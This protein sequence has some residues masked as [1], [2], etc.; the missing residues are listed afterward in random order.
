M[1]K[2]ILGIIILLFGAFKGGIGIAAM[3]GAFGIPGLL[4]V[5]IGAFLILWSIGD[6][7]KKISDYFGGQEITKYPNGDEYIGEYKDGVKHGQGTLNFANGDKYIGGFKNDIFHG[8]G[9]YTWSNGQK[10][11]G[12]WKYGDFDGKGVLIYENGT[13]EEGTFKDGKYIGK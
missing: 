3:G 11:L 13:I 8:Q 7:F 12:A 6:F 9:T 5:I 4:I 10:Y 1:L 2:F